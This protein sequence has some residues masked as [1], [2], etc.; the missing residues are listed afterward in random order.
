M[1]LPHNRPTIFVLGGINID[2][3][4]ITTRLHIPGETVKGDHFYTAPDGK[5]A[6]Q[7]VG[8]ALAV[9]KPG[10][11]EYMSSREEIENL[12]PSSNRSFRDLNYNP[13]TLVPPRDV[14]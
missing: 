8:G 6:N 4:G 11:Q 1:K 7:A 14:L 5:G 2:L 13:Q 9:T 3:I 10:A 12:M